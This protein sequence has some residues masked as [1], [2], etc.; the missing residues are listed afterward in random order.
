[1]NIEFKCS[2]EFISKGFVLDDDVTAAT[3]QT[4]ISNIYVC[5][6]EYARACL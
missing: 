6:C 3:K 4:E 2:R 1:M 5:V